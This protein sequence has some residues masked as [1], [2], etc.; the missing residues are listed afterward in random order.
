LFK[1]TDWL[2]DCLI[3]WLLSGTYFLFTQCIPRENLLGPLVMSQRFVVE[4]VMKESFSSNCNSSSCKSPSVMK[5]A[6][7][8]TAIV[9]EDD[10][11]V[12]VSVTCQH[13]FMNPSSKTLLPFL[14]PHHNSEQSWAM[15]YLKKP[16][17]GSREQGNICEV[18]SKNKGLYIFFRKLQSWRAQYG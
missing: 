11:T 6:M 18:K 10:G 2:I 13:P 17:K 1:L 14:N 9:F 5:L 4:K 3:D 16:K 12:T 8:L 7:F 15:M